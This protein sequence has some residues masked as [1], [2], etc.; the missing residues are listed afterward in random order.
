MLFTFLKKSEGPGVPS[1]S[2]EPCWGLGHR[3][4]PCLGQTVDGLSQT[5]SQAGEQEAQGADS[6]SR[7]QWNR[8]V[9]SKAK[10]V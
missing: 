9:R 2:P 10:M 4:S 6:G 7:G 3:G 1:Q 8:A 5:H